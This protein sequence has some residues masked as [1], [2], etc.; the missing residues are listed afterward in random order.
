MAMLETLKMRKRQLG[1]GISCDLR[2][3]RPRWFE[4]QKEGQYS[5][6]VMFC[7]GIVEINIGYIM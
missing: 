1:E 5:R 7:N 3:R 4:D 2:W 6:N